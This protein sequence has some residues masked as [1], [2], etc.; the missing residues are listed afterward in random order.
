VA[1]PGETPSQRVTRELRERLMAGEWK[2]GDRLPSIGELANHYGV[3]RATVV[4]ALR[5]LRD[6]GLIVST[7]SWGTF[8]A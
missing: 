3:A 6:E 2:T 7:P 1:R 5:I 4:K 8:K